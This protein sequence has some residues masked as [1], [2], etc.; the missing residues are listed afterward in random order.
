MIFF[1]GIE[2]LQ[3]NPFVRELQSVSLEANS[4]YIISCKVHK[5]PESISLR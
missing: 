3:F 5:K 2:T 4:L 1:V